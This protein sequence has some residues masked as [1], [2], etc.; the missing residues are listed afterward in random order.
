MSWQ[1]YLE[2]KYFAEV[3]ETTLF[4]DVCSVSKI[5]FIVSKGRYK[6]KKRGKY[7]IKSKRPKYL[8]G[9]GSLKIPSFR[10]SSRLRNS[11]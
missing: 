3:Y 4:K 7:L 2:T 5:R 6:A 8:W 11:A 9:N 10:G 1:V